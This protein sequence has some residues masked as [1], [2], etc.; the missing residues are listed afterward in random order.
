[1]TISKGHHNHYQEFLSPIECKRLSAFVLSEE[2]RVLDIP[3]PYPSGYKGLT[4]QHSVYNW[5]SHP[6]LKVLNIPQR[7]F[8]L[9]DFEDTTHVAIQCWMNILRQQ[10][11]IGTHEHGSDPNNPSPPFYAI[12]IFLSGNP[13]TGTHYE[14]IGHSP[15]TL[16]DIHII[17]NT[18]AHSVP[19]QLFREPRISMAMDVFAKPIDG[20]FDYLNTFL[21]N[22]EGRIIEFQRPHYDVKK[23]EGYC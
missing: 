5:L 12:N 23:F 2:Q 4:G 16:G 13:T 1:M 21:D 6:T 19:S 7:L 14:D 15:N 17:E 18:L 3:N 8:E 10:E 11:R 20:T 22:V 9:P